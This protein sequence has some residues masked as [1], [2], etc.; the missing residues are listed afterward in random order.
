M[1]EVEGIWRSADCIHAAIVAIR[2]RSF[3]T[4]V[5]Q[6]DAGMVV[7]SELSH[8]PIAASLERPNSAV[9]ASK[10]FDRLPGFGL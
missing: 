10:R 3:R 7:L 5:L 2:A 8:Y 4:K 6:D 9:V 1:S